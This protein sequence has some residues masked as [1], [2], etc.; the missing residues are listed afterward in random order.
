MNDER[1]FV[2]NNDG[3]NNNKTDG[4]KTITMM[5]KLTIGKNSNKID[6]RIKSK[7]DGKNNNVDNNNIYV[8]QLVNFAV[9][10]Y[11]LLITLSLQTN[12][13]SNK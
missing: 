13:S 11:L 8:A 6:G 10:L 12:L 2:N 7:N 4:K 9:A 5:V 3:R 1:P